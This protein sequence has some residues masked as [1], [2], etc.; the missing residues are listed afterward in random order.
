[1]RRVAIHRT[2]TVFFVQAEAIAGPAVSAIILNA[3]LVKGSV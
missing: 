3:R 1:M 2:V